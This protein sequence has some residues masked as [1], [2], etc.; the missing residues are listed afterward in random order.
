MEEKRNSALK[1]GIDEIVICQIP[2]FDRPDIS[3]I[4]RQ[5]KQSGATSVQIY[6]F[7]KDFEPNKEGE[8]EWDYFDRQVN[9]LKAAGL[10]WVPFLILGPK[11]AAPEWWLKDSRHKGLVCLEHGK[12]S[13]IDSIWNPYLIGQIDRVV[14]AFAEHYLPMDIIESFQPGICGDY[15]ES[16]MPV[17][18][19][20]PGDYH[21]HPGFWC[22]DDAARASFKEACFKKYGNINALNKAW[23]SHYSDFSEIEPFLPH[24][25]TSRTSYFDQINWYRDSMTDFVDKWMQISRKYFPDTPIYMCTGG[26]EAPEHA[27]DFAAQAKV[28]AK[29]N[30]GIRLTNECNRFFE[31]F[32]CT[33]YTHSAC[34]FYGAYLGLEPVG[35]LTPEGVKARMFGSAV[36]G[37]RQMMYYYYNLFK[38][39]SFEGE[40]I[41]T[42]NTDAFMQ[43][44]HLLNETETKT[45]T[46]FFWQG[47]M[48]AFSDGIPPEIQPIATFLRKL[49][50]ISPVNERMIADG[51]LDNY[52]LL[53]I[54]NGG[55]TDRETLLKIV[56]Y[57]KN[58]GTVLALGRMTDLELEPVREFDELFGIMPESD[59]GFGGARYDIIN[60]GYFPGFAEVGGYNAGSGFIG[61]HP[62]TVDITRCEYN[63][64]NYSGT[65]TAQMSSCFLREYI[66]ENG[67]KGTAIAYFGPKEFVFDAQNLHSQKPVFPSFM[68]DVLSKY[69]DSKLLNTQPGEQARGFINGRLY[70]LTDSFEI[71][72]LNKQ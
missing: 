58:G 66:A 63:P 21:T 40:S 57:V 60:N 22:G 30:A 53:I 26:C 6:T 68:K 51:A 33:S 61:L 67:K 11:Y 34:E 35:P 9:L 19:N 39:P 64:N 45:D 24:K 46:A 62:G 18:G 59:I 69:T 3:D 44:L 8:F 29:Y 42:G 37:N 41:Y 2:S 47:Y 71:V 10:K 65:T 55:F 28:C 32:F 14:K 43:H 17:H 25:A 50:A 20:W 1:P 38:E 16:I 31:N 48:G 23:N 56:S 7:W 72:E 15:G 54:P 5:I 36:Y 70:A 52:K 27:S 4:L 49:T 12:T 13:P